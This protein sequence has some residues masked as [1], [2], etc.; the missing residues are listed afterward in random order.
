MNIYCDFTNKLAS[1]FSTSGNLLS[2][3]ISLSNVKI[4]SG[5]SSATLANLYE[6]LKSDNSP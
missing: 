5:F 6:N 1:G 3:S 2:T 4:L